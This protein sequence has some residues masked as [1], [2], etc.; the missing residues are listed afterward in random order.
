MSRGLLALFAKAP[1]PG[2]VKTRLCPP[3]SFEQAASLYEAMLLDVLDRPLAAR[4]VDRALWFAPASAKAWFEQAAGGYR[5]CAQQGPDLAERM[6]RAFQQHAEEGY[7]RIVLRGT[8][9]P[10]L[11]DATVAAAFS[12]L[13]SAPVVLCP[14]RDGGYNLIGLRE[15]SDPLFD[16]ELSTATVLDRTLARARELGLGVELL[17]PHHDVDRFEDLA[18]IRTDERTPRTARWLEQARD[19][20]SR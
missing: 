8:D 11:P 18:R 16:L 7:E 15:P 17:P 20:M 4:G 14:D 3:L 19:S 9:S 5:L 2:Q 6:C 13:E 1:M 12:R 10:T